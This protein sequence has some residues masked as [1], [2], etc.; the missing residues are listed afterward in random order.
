MSL[1][2][3]YLINSLKKLTITNQKVKSFGTEEKGNVLSRLTNLP[4]NVKL[5]LKLIVSLVLIV[6]LFLFGRVDL[7]KAGELALTANLKLFALAFFLA[8]SC[9]FLNAYRWQA[10]AKA[11]G[12]ERGLLELTQYCFVGSFFNLFMP[13]TVGGDV[14]RGYYL[15]KG[16]GRYKQA[17]YSIFADRAVGIAILFLFAC[18]GIVLSPGGRNLPIQ[19]KLPIFLGTF[20]IFFAIPLMPHISQFL[21]GKEHWLTQRFNNSTVQ[22]FWKDKS[23][24]LVA[25]W[26]SIILQTI[27]VICHILVGLALGLTNIPYW[28]Y[29]VFY[30][31]VAVLGFITPSFNGVGIRE[32][33]YTFFL[34]YMGIDR[35]HALLYAL[36]WLVLNYLIGLAGGLVY[37][38]GHYHF[39]QAMAQEVESDL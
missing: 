5:A 12:L 20:A 2:S 29:F 33:A 9:T 36:A 37:L 3:L 13:S 15:A 21:L 27:F 39:S 17:F 14:A 4:K 22:V 26:Q 30:P 11:V 16:K 8:C 28:Y 35:P 23:L 34:M 25:L 24:I 18:L 10:L 6:G 32:W 19:L 38:L 1:S 7:A 31:C